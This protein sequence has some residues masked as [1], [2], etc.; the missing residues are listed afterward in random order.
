[1][2]S[3]YV[4][5]LQPKPPPTSTAMTRNLFSGKPRTSTTA[6]RSRWG[7]GWKAIRS[8]A[9][10]AFVAGHH[11]PGFQ[12]ARDEA[13][14][15]RRAETTPSAHGRRGR[16]PS[17]P[18]A[19]DAEIG[20]QIPWTRVPPS[21]AFSRS[22]TAGS[23]RN[24]PDHFQGILSDHWRPTPPPRALPHTSRPQSPWAI[25]SWCACLP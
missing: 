19:F 3:G 5:I 16:D 2:V 23:D 18:R 11:G 14:W 22:I 4:S 25:C 24:R 1:M 12:G 21:S 8:V 13:G 20:A 9:G 6:L 17:P 15:T 7:P 10:A